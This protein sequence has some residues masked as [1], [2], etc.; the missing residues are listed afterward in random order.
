VSSTQDPHRPGAGHRSQGEDHP[1][2]LGVLY[3]STQEDADGPKDWA[4]TCTPTGA[5]LGAAA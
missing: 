3:G 4:D 2:R 5:V 1:D